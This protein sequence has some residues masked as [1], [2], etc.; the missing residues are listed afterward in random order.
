[1][2][3]LERVSYISLVM[4]LVSDSAIIGQYDTVRRCHPAHHVTVTGDMQFK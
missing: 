3:Y 1:M 2:N 4:S